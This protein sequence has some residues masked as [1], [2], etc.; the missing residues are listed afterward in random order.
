MPPQLLERAQGLISNSEA[1][2]VP[3]RSSLPAI[4]R[5]EDNSVVSAITV[6]ILTILFIS[7]KF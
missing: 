7:F 5:G 1:P 4:R 6:N 2:G 3:L